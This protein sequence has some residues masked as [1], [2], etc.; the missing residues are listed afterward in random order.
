MWSICKCVKR[1]STRR[2]DS[3]IVAAK[4]RMPVP[5]SS[6]SIVP[7]RPTTPTHEV[8]PP[9]RAISGPGVASEPRVP[10]RVTCISKLPEDH[11]RAE[12]LPLLADERKCGDVHV[13]PLPLPT[14]HPHRSGER[15]ALGERHHRGP[16]FRCNGI[17]R[18]IG[19][20]EEPR[21]L[22]GGHLARFV[23]A[24]IQ[25]HLRRFVVEDERSL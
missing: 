22:V 16:V 8:F 5:A 23:K 17:A 21:P 6:T 24:L 15:F 20:R 12:E 2:R 18:L 10:H 19:H 1:M 7:S 3:G 11:L 25:N 13:Q 4:R 9:Y 14:A